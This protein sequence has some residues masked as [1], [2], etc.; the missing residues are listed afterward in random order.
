MKRTGRKKPTAGKRSDKALA[1]VRKFFPTV[2]RVVDATKGI[3]IEVTPADCGRAKKKAHGECALAVACK[4]V[5]GLDGVIVSRSTVYL[6]KHRRATRYQMLESTAKEI[7]AFDRGAYFD[8]G[9]YCL[10]PPAHPLGERSASPGSY[11]G[12]RTGEV[13]EARRHYTSGVRTVLGGR[14]ENSL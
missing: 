6:I 9:E 11:S 10:K 14:R 2:N 4:R 1:I 13:A 5:C 7:V 12:E 3:T 8:P